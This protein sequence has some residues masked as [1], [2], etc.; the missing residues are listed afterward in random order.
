MPAATRRIDA[1]TATRRR[2]EAQLR[3]TAQSILLSNNDWYSPAQV[4]DMINTLA[5]LV[6]ASVTQ[7]GVLTQA[8]LQGLYE[9]AG[10]AP[11][12]PKT[13]IAGS[14]RLGVS[15]SEAYNRVPAEYRM[16]ISRGSSHEEALDLSMKRLST[17][18]ATDLQIGHREMS[19]RITAVN[20][21][22]TT[23]FR[24]IIRPE[25]SAGN[26]CGLCI[27][28]ADRV[29]SISELMPLHNGCHCDIAPIT[30]DFDPGISLNREDLD[31]LYAAAGDSTYGSQL[32]QVKLAVK[33]HGEIGPIM[34]PEGEDTT[35]ARK[36]FSR[37]KPGN[38][39]Y[40]SRPNFDAMIASAEDTISRLE[41][42]L[43][44]GVGDASTAAALEWQRGHLSSLQ[45]RKS[46]S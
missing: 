5:E 39:S 17:M 31:A 23:G 29:Y 25:L 40:E 34:T 16:A 7:E 6:D 46:E 1:H 15:T 32:R 14:Q 21:R 38:R 28:A 4:R 35:G 44:A 8:F 20:P 42:E 37:A 10:V 3:R 9:D 13:M 24:R 30:R 27:A 18:L 2:R 43:A 19:R 12:T 41:Q 33:D 22:T 11:N 45:Q 26:V 36:A